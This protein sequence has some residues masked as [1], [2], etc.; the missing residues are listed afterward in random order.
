MFDVAE[1]KAKK[2]DELQVIAKSLGLKKVTQIKKQDLIYSIL[3]LQALSNDIK[4]AE[5][6]PPKNTSA[7]MKKPA[8]K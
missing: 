4:T 2:L 8:E 6:T 1:L 5:A 3:D 7:P